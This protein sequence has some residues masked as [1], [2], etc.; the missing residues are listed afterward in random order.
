MSVC[1]NNFSSYMCVC[2]IL[3]M[4]VKDYSSS[5]KSS[6]QSSWNKLLNKKHISPH[7]CPIHNWLLNFSINFSMN[8]HVR[9]LVAW[10]A[11]LPSC[12]EKVGKLHTSM[13]LSEHMLAPYDMTRSS[14]YRVHIHISLVLNLFLFSS[15]EHCP[16][17]KQTL[18]VIYLNK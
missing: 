17:K 5:I 11:G 6:S 7:C 1:P 13:L 14:P 15:S 12:P 8:P 3:C 10:S 16:M 2:L 4:W 18:F 9:L